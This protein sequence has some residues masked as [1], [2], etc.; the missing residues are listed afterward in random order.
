MVAT[1]IALWLILIILVVVGLVMLVTQLP[2]LPDRVATHFDAAGRP[3]GFMSR[4]GHFATMVA[5][6]VGTPIFFAVLSVLIRVLPVSLINI[7]YRSYWL[8]PER[9]AETLRVVELFVWIMA[10]CTE[11]FMIGMQQL[12]YRAN[13]EHGRLS[14]TGFLVLVGSYLVVTLGGSV[15]LLVRFW[16][17]PTPPTSAP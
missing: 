2:D 15:C 10:V 17:P 12:V 3:N 16:R 8:A 5:V 13:V 7:P 1:R 11:L 4:Q 6:L 14:S 9:R